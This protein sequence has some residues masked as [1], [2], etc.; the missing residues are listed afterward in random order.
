MGDY[1]ILKA[2]NLIKIAVPTSV[3]FRVDRTMRY[4]SYIPKVGRII[5]I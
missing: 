2:C 5:T 1:V 3:T 4:L